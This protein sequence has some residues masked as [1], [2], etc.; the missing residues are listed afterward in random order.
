MW[1]SR[2][3]IINTNS[4]FMLL[5]FS[6][7]EPFSLLSLCNTSNLPPVIMNLLQS[8]FIIIFK[9]YL[10]THVSFL[11]LFLLTDFSPFMVVFSCFFIYLV[12]FYWIWQT[13]QI[14]PFWESWYFLYFFKY[15]WALYY[16]P[17][18]MLGKKSIFLKLASKLF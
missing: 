2:S 14:L 13:L 5:I 8:R 6:F 4:F 16:D 17:V 1:K 7:L 10:C 9:M 18:K 12:N 11:D 15:S 3:Q